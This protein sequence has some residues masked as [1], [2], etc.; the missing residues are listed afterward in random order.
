MCQNIEC[1]GQGSSYGGGEPVRA[2]SET[3]TRS[4]GRPALERCGTSPEG[5]SSSRARQ[6]FVSAVLCP[7]SE[8]EFHL[9]VAG[10]VRSGGPLRPSGPC[11][12]ATRPLLSWVCLFVL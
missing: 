9:R 2:S 5:P 4:R 8:A 1:P 3:E 11:A 12:L 10:A 6:S 7:S